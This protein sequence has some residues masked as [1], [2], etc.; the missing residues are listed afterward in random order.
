MG[1][2]SLTGRRELLDAA[3][4]ELTARPGVLF[5]GPLGIGKS[6][7]VAALTASLAAH[8]PSG[9]TVLHCSPAEEDARLPFVGLVDLF[10]RVPE[11]C[12]ETLAPEPRAALRAALLR[13]AEPADGRGRLAVRVAVLGVLRTL[14][15][16]GPV[17]LVLDGLQWLDDHTAEVLAFAVRRLGDLDIRVVAAER[18]ADGEQPERPHCCPPGTLELPVPPLTD[19]D[20]ARLL[21]TGTG[22]DLPP[23]V[24]R[25]I[26]DTA[27]GNPLYALELGRAAALRGP[28]PVA[29][30]PTP[31][32]PRRL[33][34]LL[35]DETRT[36]PE[37]ARRTLLVTSAATRPDLTL[38]RAAG[39]PDPAAD[40]AEAERLGVAATDTDGTVRFRHPLIRAAVYADATESERRQAH[41]LLARVLREPVEQA[42]HLA[43][44]RPHEDE[45]TART[46]M[47]AAEHAR[48]DGALGT[49]CELAGLAARRTPG[50]R[51]ADRADR[52]LAAAEYACDA[53]QRE[54]A[55]EAAEA[56][57]AES[58]SARRRVR[59]RLVLLRNAGQA[60]EGAHALIQDGLRDAVGDPGAEAP[61]HHWAAV[62][63]LLCGELEE[64]AGHARRAAG[65][66][67]VA[68]DTETRIGALATLARVRSLAGDPV[69][70][71]AALEGA[72]ALAGGADG[73]P[74]S[75]RLIRMRAILALD[76]DR[77]TEAAEQVGQLLPAIE[78]LAG[79]EEVM[80][81]LVA[82]T[83]IQVRA[84]HCHEALH[85]A[86]RCSRA[87]AEAAPAL[88]AVA[89]AAAAGG[90]A[91]EARRL[92][93]QAVRASEA[94]G[95]RLFLL[96]SLAVLGQAGLLA[97]DPRGA[98]S[99][100]E[101]LQRVRE[102]GTA[103]CAADPPV[104]H[105]YGDLAEALVL[106]GETDEAGAVLREA[107]A[108]VTGD[109]PGS[110][111]AALERAEGLREARSGRAK[112]GAAR[113]R[114]AADRLR[115]L[116]LPAELVRTLIA[117]GAVERRSRRRSAAR[118][119]LG[120][121]LQTATRI[122]AA[123]LAA[124]A[125]DE[126]SRLD[127]GDRSGEAGAG[128]PELTPTEARIAELVGGGAT[129]R[130]VAAKLFISVKTVEG[131]L[132]RVYRKVGV[133]S[134]TAL[135]HA[136]AV[137]VIASGSAVD[138][139]GDDGQG[140]PPGPAVLVSRSSRTP[141]H[142]ALD[143]RR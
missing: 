108:R 120:E 8:A 25:A 122:G 127:A 140:G 87:M 35:L 83:R 29:F 103:M 10:A 65:Q 58:D 19:D 11:S 47:S 109:T 92:A 91:E 77:V 32:V 93:E 107:R 9:G 131:T 98:A 90:T 61:L 31:P 50:D 33:R 17:V 85:T 16:T 45:N 76:S 27:A 128:R 52:L 84:G 130:E 119:V 3:R 34:A 96:R 60:L 115:H 106:L 41:A 95:D 117:L 80:A 56:V 7:L 129:N 114:A 6:M 2:R 48:R 15:A 36:L 102:L 53:G 112:D 79:V 14:A 105:W 22:T 23:S 133:R 100:V 86:A 121:A 18:V 51:P 26:Q 59:A 54:E 57:L 138:S 88:Y 42:R 43:H 124:R 13:G 141:A 4:A 5:H 67:A 81:T 46:L 69:A 75:W 12:P 1:A 66:A 24:L 73:G 113:L 30:G 99:A 123:P 63:G 104:L 101:A 62:R 44:A 132:S 97:G 126:L 68:G 70:A 94:D 71:E 40:L 55:A 39:L 142:H 110:A 72:L 135:A 20:V 139:G 134:R 21:R 116:P 125:R 118:A 143:T 49:A 74:Q 37:T 137:A 64:A 38:L 78:E 111:L 89:L 82:L 28:G 136:M